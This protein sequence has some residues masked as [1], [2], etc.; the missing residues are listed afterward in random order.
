VRRLTTLV[1]ALALVVPGSAVAA[2]YEPVNC[3]DQAGSDGCGTESLQDLSSAAVA[4]PDRKQVYSLSSGNFGPIVQYDRDAATGALTRHPGTAGCLV[5]V[6]EAPDDRGHGDRAAPH[7][8]GLDGEGRALHRTPRQG[9]ELADAL[10]AAGREAR[11]RLQ[12]RIPL[13]LPAGKV[14]VWLA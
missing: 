12:Y 2:V 7:E 9:P 10:P 5:A 3:F 13:G 4:S 8:A 6:Q 11:G 14:E 1:A